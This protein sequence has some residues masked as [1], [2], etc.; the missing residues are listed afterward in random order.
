MW[1]MGVM[2]IASVV[3]VLGHIVGGIANPISLS[4]VS[5]IQLFAAGGLTLA[6]LIV[7]HVFDLWPS[8]KQRNTLLVHNCLTPGERGPRERKVAV[9]Y[10]APAVKGKRTG[11]RHVDTR[12]WGFLWKNPEYAALFERVIHSRDLLSTEVLEELLSDP[13]TA[14]P[15]LRSLESGGWASVSTTEVK[16]ARTV[17][18]E[19]EYDMPHPDAR[20]VLCVLSAM[21]HDV[22]QD[23]QITALAKGALLSSNKEI[24]EIGIR[25][26]GMIKAKPV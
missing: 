26:F 21:R 2:M 12:T 11:M 10:A 14:R 18:Q 8:G 19:S 6:N 7:C 24:R 23:L 13:E 3:I 25:I 22:A 20:L 5:S 1:A 15:V 17:S 16:T 9:G 4:R